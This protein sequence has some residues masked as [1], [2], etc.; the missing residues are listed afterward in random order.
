MLLRCVAAVRERAASAQIDGAE[1]GLGD[2]ANPAQVDRAY[3]AVA[4]FLAAKWA[5]GAR[6]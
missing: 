6:L 2:A 4:D 1:H 3:S 5:G